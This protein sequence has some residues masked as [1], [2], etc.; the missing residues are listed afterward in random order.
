MERVSIVAGA[1]NL[2]NCFSFHDSINSIL[3]QTYTD[4]E[5]I[6]CDDGS[7][8]RTWELLCEYAEKDTRIK[9]LKNESNLGLAASLNRCIEMAE[10]EYIARHDLD[11]YCDVT[12]IEKQLAYL[13]KHSEIAFVGTQAYLF[14]EKGVWG[15]EHF[16]TEVSNKE[17]LFV[18]PYQHGSVMF[19]K[20]ELL[21][22]GCYRVAKETRR[23]EDYDLFMTL[24]SFCKGANMDEFLY[25]FC[26]NKSAKKRRKYRYRIDEMKVRFKGFKKLKLMPKGF[27]YAIKP[28]IVGLIPSGMLDKL[29]SKR[30]RRE[31]IRE[32]D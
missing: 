3:N 22:A 5:L 14:D 32:K 18:S 27:F 13:K 24:H 28:L 12:R 8:D 9:L 19:R 16:P 1:Y 11:D 7:T 26:E 29:K 25:Y 4:I 20:K 2:E 23:A 30:S 10:G 6:I 21:Q 17:F 15:K 31:I